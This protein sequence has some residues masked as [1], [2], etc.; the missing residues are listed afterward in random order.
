MSVFFAGNRTTF[1]RR[2]RP[3][4]RRPCSPS[5]QSYPAPASSPSPADINTLELEIT[6]VDNHSLP[7]TCIIL[8]IINPFIHV[9]SLSKGWCCLPSAMSF[10]ES[11]GG[12]SRVRRYNHSLAV[13][14]GRLLAAAWGTELLVRVLYKFL[15][16]CRLP[17]VA[18]CTE[19]G[20]REHDWLHGERRP[21]DPR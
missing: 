4:C 3:I 15:S 11:L 13:R 8:N 10:I 17:R 18:H 14:A 5:Q 7:L 2:L 12:L 6:R 16:S 19:T 1:A 20:A 21:P 9:A